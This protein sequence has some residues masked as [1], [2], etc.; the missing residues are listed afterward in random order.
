MKVELGQ[1][2]L[3]YLLLWCKK[4]VRLLERVVEGFK[5]GTDIGKKNLDKK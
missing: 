3:I 5:T 1:K 2:I 4:D